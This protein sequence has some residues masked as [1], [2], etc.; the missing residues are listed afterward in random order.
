MADQI[1]I[2]FTHRFSSGVDVHATL[3][4]FVPPGSILV[5][6]GPSGAGKTTVLR[7]V[8][9]LLRP[10]R[11]RISFGDAT[12][13]DSSA[14]RFVRPQERRV[15]YITQDT[16]LFPH[17]TVKANIEYGGRARTA[18][19][20]DLIHLRGLEGR[21]PKQLSG[22][23]AQRVALA[24]ALAPAPPLVLFDEPF[25]AL[26]V[27]TRRSLRPDVRRLLRD[28]GASAI[29][30]TH[31]RLEAMAMG[32]DLAVMVDGRIRQVGPMAE[33]FRR[34]ADSAVARSLGV[35]TIQ[36]ALVEANDEGL[37]ALRVRDVVLAALAEGPC[38]IG[39]QVFACI[40]AEDVVVELAG[41]GEQPVGASARNHLAGRVVA[42]EPE[43]A[44]E[45]VTIDCGFEL[46]AVIT[47]QSRDALALAPGTPVAAAIKATAIH[48]VPKT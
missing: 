34:P 28:V 20:I 19:L 12:W 31:D 42:I 35:E 9:G 22:G 4:R 13:F 43:G 7:A 17:L 46:V 24:R 29:L 16:L 27:A 8:A 26:D 21:Y 3:D 38:A 47:R 37:V 48:V 32:D 1:R 10:D 41:R 11:G 36:P 44:V 6:F 23:Q 45:R 5:L 33:V 40:R 2:D 18:E 15:G 39:D 25:A 14:K 30:I